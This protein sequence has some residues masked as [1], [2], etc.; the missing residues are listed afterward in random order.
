MQLFRKLAGNILFKIILAFV[1]VSFVLFGVS[2]FILGSPNSWVAKIG[3]TTISYNAFNKAVKSDRD[4]IASSAKSEE[5]MK[6]L[7]SERFKSEVLGRLV[8][9]IMIEKITDDL[10]IVSDRKIILENIAKDQSFKNEA[11]KFDHA[12]FKDFLKKN[13]INE[14]RYVSEIATETSAQMTLQS[15]AMAAPMNNSSILAAENFKQEKRIAD[16]IT[17]SQKNIRQPAQPNQEELEKFFAENRQQ[18]ALPEMRKISYL[19]FSKKDFSKDFQISNQEILAEYEK[20][21]DQFV[22]P[23]SRNFYHLLFEK[24]NEAKEFLNKFDTSASKSKSEFA[25]LAKELQKKNLKEIELTKITQKDLIPQ[26]ADQV[27]QLAINENSEVLQ[28]P[29]G[30]HIFFLTEI[31]PSHPL[32]FAEVKDAIKQQLAQNRDDKVL[33]EKISAIDDALLTSNSLSEVAKKFNLKTPQS[34]TIDLGG[35]QNQIKSFDNFAQNAFALQT[36]QTSKIFYAKNSDGFY[37]LKVDEIFPAHE[38]NLDEVKTQLVQNFIQNKKME[39]VAELAKKVGDEIKQNP[40]SAAQIAAKYRLLFEKNHEFPRQF[41]VAFQGRQLAFQ[42]KLLQNLFNL[43]IGQTTS[44]LSEKDGEFKIGILRQIK[45]TNVNS[46]QFAEA[47]KQAEENFKNE[48]MQ[49]YNS[50]LLKKFPVKVNEKIIGKK[51]ES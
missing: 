28:S 10:G 48:V 16:I 2:D 36:N 6:Y 41:Y 31:K 51:D 30:F 47:Q 1:A 46:S 43:K 18:Y 44:A 17:I 4:I 24:E 14:E 27:F 45:E 26:L 21:K 32:P 7:E 23:E 19:H 35:E 11:G 34:V 38:R 29:L 9:K 13:G 3:D 42:S 25:Q 8:N 40:D 37:A 50:Y 49:E 5:A 22:S 12:R 39:A 33:Q 20:N 15:L